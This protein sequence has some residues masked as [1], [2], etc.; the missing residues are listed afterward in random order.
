M[1]TEVSPGVGVAVDAI[2]CNVV[3]FGVAVV[4]TGVVFT[5]VDTF[6][7]GAVCPV[8]RFAAII[9]PAMNARITITTSTIGSLPDFFDT[10]A[11]GTGGG[12]EGG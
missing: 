12:E 4:V 11:E 1:E 5:G 8:P 7:P 6:A 3:G 2:V 9:S 10:G